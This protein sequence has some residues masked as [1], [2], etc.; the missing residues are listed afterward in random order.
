MCMFCAAVPAAAALGAT[1]NVKKKKNANTAKW[2][3]SVPV[4]TTTGVVIV[5]LMAG[6]V[7][8]HSQIGPA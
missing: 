4:A 6:S 7:A 8:Y 5:A 2:L 1:A 3:L